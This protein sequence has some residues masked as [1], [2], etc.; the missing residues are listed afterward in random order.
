MEL[1]AA[2]GISNA[3]VS[4]QKYV[5][6][7]HIQSLLYSKREFPFFVKQSRFDSGL[8]YH[9]NSFLRS[10]ASQET[11]CETT[12]HDTDVHE[13]EPDPVTAVEDISPDDRKEA[14]DIQLNEGSEGGFD[15]FFQLF[16]FLEDID[17]KFDYEEAYT[18][19]VYGGGGTVAVWLAAAVVGAIDSIPVL[20][21]VLELVGLGYMLWFTSRYLIFKRNRDELVARIEQ[22]K[23]QVLGSNDD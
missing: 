12:P 21:K 14:F 9:V 2:R 5:A 20:P 13:P 19:F 1:C 7:K 18:V 6:S 17:I 15:N 22:I 3:H 11:S 10:T 23:Q 4:R 16:K 8:R